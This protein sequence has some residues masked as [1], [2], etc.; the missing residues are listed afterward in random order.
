MSSQNSGVTHT[1]TLHKP[2][3]LG[4]TETEAPH[5]PREDKS[6]KWLRRRAQVSGMLSWVL[7]GFGSPWQLLVSPGRIPVLTRENTFSLLHAK[8]EAGPPALAPS[9]G[10]CQNTAPH[11]HTISAQMYVQMK[12]KTTCAHPGQ[13]H[14]A[15]SSLL[16]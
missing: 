8:P 4:K 16:R 5:R 15:T 1:A 6:A 2:Y 10:T 7:E 3:S 11:R 9:A 12:T 13:L 14:E